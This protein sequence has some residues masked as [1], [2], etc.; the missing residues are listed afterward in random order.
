MLLGPMAILGVY[1]LAIPESII[2]LNDSIHVVFTYMVPIFGLIIISTG[3]LIHKKQLDSIIKLDDLNERILNYHRISIIRFALIEGVGMFALMAYIMTM[4]PVYILYLII[5]SIVF[6]PILPSRIKTFK[7]L[8]ISEEEL[9]DFDSSTTKRDDSQKKKA[10]L[11]FPILAFILFL[12]YDDYKDLLSNS[13][14]L[15]EIEVDSGEILDSLYYNDYLNWS[16][17]IPNGLLVICIF[18]KFFV[19][20]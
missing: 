1:S 10:W 14:R 12:T 13:V 6:L 18:S 17:I 2:M 11:I 16:F 5:I 20:K 8:K 4:R 3:F 19:L 9:V 7:I 15:P